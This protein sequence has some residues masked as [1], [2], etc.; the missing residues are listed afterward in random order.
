MK[1]L[2]PNTSLPFK[3]GDLRED[4]FVFCSYTSRLKSNG[5]FCESWYSP[6][7]WKKNPIL[8]LTWQRNNQKL[9]NQKSSKWR[10]ENRDTCNFLLAKYKS[11]KKLRTPPWLNNDHY[12]EIKLWYRR[13]KLASIFFGEAYEVDHVIP[14]QGK[15]VSGLHVPWNLQILTKNENVKKSNKI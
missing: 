5:Y 1:R 15:N 6:N 7:A 4:G 11:N 2:N 3:R 12:K 9:H 13:A 8:K 14:L 10:K